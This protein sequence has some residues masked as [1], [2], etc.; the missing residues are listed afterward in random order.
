MSLHVVGCSRVIADHFIILYAEERWRAKGP[1]HSGCG[2]S[3]QAFT[4]CWGEPSK[5]GNF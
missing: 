1:W 5:C 2:P 3:V 4:L